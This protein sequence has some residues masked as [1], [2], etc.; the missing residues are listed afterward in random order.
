MSNIWDKHVKDAYGDAVDFLPEQSWN[1]ATIPHF[2]DPRVFYCYAYSFGMLFVLGLYQ[3]YL[4]EGESFI[5]K[6][7]QI[8]EAG[9]SQFPVDL[10]NSVGLD[11]TT[12]DFWQAGFDYL[13]KLLKEFQDIVDSRV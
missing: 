1:W 3:K 6:Y 5:P 4:E 11:L 2:L 9:G 7:K 8:L 12:P 13:R 10:A